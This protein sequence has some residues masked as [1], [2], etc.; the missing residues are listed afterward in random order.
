[1]RLLCAVAAS[2]LLLL[3]AL[4]PLAPVSTW[5][6]AKLVRLVSFET[7][8]RITYAVLFGIGLK[9]LWDGASGLLQAAP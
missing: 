8:Y 5:F 6:G 7:F 4:L 9:L 3:A 1:M 2:G